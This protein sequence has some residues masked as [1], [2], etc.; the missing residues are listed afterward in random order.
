MCLKCAILVTDFRKSPTPGVS[1]IWF[2]WPEVEWLGQIAFFFQTDY[3]EIKLLR[4]Q[5]S[6]NFSD[7]IIITFP[8]YVTKLT[9]QDF[10]I[11]GPSQSKF[12]ATPV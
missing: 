8:K 2:W 5:L 9:S 1:R 10:S 4:N 6:R 7:V 12:L 3:D 11:L